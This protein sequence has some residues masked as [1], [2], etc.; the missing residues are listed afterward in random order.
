M[1]QFQT[2][3]LFNNRISFLTALR[4]GSP[5]SRLTLDQGFSWLSTSLWVFTHTSS[6][7]RCTPTPSDLMAVLMT[8][9]DLNYLLKVL[10]PNAIYMGLRTSVYEWV[11]G[12]GGQEMQVHPEQ[13]LTLI[14]SHFLCEKQNRA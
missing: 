3:G 8:S 14:C 10:A 6:L 7:L 4:V 13:P 1:A 12:R 2:P 5:G 9:F 11:A